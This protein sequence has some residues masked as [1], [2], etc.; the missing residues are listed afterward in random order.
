MRTSLRST[1]GGKPIDDWN[2]LKKCARERPASFASVSMLASPPALERMYSAA[3]LIR[4]S[5]ADTFNS[6]IDLGKLFQGVK[7]SITAIISSDNNASYS[8][9][10]SEPAI[11]SDARSIVSFRM[12]GDISPWEV[13]KN[14]GAPLAAHPGR[15]AFSHTGSTYRARISVQIG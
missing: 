12:P 5:H 10:H 4:R 11:I 2:S 8:A 6:R 15:K 7:R 1:L 3:R 9:L 13:P 14:P